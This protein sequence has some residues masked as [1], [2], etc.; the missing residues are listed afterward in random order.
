MLAQVV[1]PKMCVGHFG[2][3]DFANDLPQPPLGEATKS[4]NSGLKKTGA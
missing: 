4:A 1:L 2:S 3:S